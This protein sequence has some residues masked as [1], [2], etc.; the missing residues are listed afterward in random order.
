MHSLVSVP[1]SNTTFDP[2]AT[3]AAAAAWA[4]GHSGRPTA[5]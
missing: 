4:R 5:S 2:S 1:N 3:A